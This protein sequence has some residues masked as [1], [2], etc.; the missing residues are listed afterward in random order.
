MSFIGGK[1]EIDC[2]LIKITTIIAHFMMSTITRFYRSSRPSHQYFVNLPS[3]LW[4]QILHTN[5][6]KRELCYMSW[7]HF[8]AT[9]I[10]MVEFAAYEIKRATAPKSLPMHLPVKEII[11]MC[12]HHEKIWVRGDWRL[13]KTMIFTPLNSSK[14]EAPTSDLIFFQFK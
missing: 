7:I 11:L 3:E 4:S 2:I 5:I 6:A 8:W 13:L 9:W 14:C 10:E 12:I 1:I